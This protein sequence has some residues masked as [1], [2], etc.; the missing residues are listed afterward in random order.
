MIKYLFIIVISILSLSANAQNTYTNDFQQFRENMLKDYDGFRKT[1]MEDYDKYLDGVWKEYEKF[2][3]HK[4]DKSPKPKIIPTFKPSDVPDNPVVVEPVVPKPTPEPKTPVKP[5]MPSTPQVPSTP[6]IPEKPNVPS[7]PSTPTSLPRMI[8]VNFYGNNIK[9]PAIEGDFVV[10]PVNCRSDIGKAWKAL[11]NSCLRN[12]LQSIKNILGLLGMSDWG[13]AMLIEKYSETL[14]PQCDVDQQRIVTQFI[15]SNLGYDIRL[16]TN[17]NQIV[18]LIPFAEIIYDMS[19]LQIEGKTFYIYPD[20]NGRLMTCDL[21]QGDTGRMMG[22]RFRGNI[23]IGSQ[24]RNF[25]LSGAGI[26]VQGKVNT[27]IM[28]L[29]NNYV[30][31]GISDIARC[32]VDRDLRNSIVEQVREQ[33]KGLNELQAANKILQFVQYA[34]D[35]ATDEE[36]FG[37]EKYFFMEENLFYPKNDCEDRSVFFAYL[38]R[39]VLHLPVHLVHY[40]GHECTAIAYSYP[41]PNSVSYTYDG[42]KYYISDPTYVGANIGMCMPEFLNVRPEIEEW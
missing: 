4:R 23:N 33:V 35:Y 18:L 9:M 25:S 26:R 38:I 21:P 27:A 17:D 1:I 7:I 34:F 16:A 3:G 31:L 40:P 29:L 13:N 32:N 15:L 5:S 30:S 41:L 36:Q 28:P 42:K 39:E 22:T 11:K 20:N 6:T 8:V 10:P 2:T 37:Y 19:Y 24:Y 12:N 14:F